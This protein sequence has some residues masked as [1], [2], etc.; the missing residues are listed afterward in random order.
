MGRDVLP[1]LISPALLNPLS[2]P[3]RCSFPLNNS[4]SNCTHCFSISSGARGGAAARWH[5]N[6][7]R[8]KDYQGFSWDDEIRANDKGEEFGF[9]ST[10]NQ[11]IWWSGDEYDIEDEETGFDGFGI[12]E[13]SIGSAW[14]MKGT[15][16]TKK[17]NATCS[18]NDSKKRFLR[19]CMDQGH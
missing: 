9:G 10:A 19:C 16:E 17:G 6:S 4:A 3:L 12:M 8:P 13:G 18:V 15:A 1:F 11:H 7:R 14:V 2:S 5:S